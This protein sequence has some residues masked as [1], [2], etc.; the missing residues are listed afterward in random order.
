MRFS[1][2]TNHARKR[3]ELGLFQQPARDT[4]NDRVEPIEFV[5]SR[6]DAGGL[7]ASGLGEAREGGKLGLPGR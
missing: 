5:T 7:F 2:S 1:I 6:S 4:E 3:P